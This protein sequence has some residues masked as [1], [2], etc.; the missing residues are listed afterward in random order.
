MLEKTKYQVIDHPSDLGIKIFAKDYKDLFLNAAFAIYDLMVS[1]YPRENIKS[2]KQDIA[3]Q[4]ANFEELLVEWL[5][6]IHFLFD[7]KQILFNDI[8]IKSLKDTTISAVLRGENIEKNNRYKRAHL[9]KAIT[10]H[11]LEIK[12]LKK[13]L[14][15]TV[16]FDV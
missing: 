9:I 14:E 12:E 16:V 15:A 13:G 11:M 10:Y 6:E 4:A 5:R 2:I 7:A 3:L 1:P 8:K